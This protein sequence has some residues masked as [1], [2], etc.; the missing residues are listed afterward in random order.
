MPHPTLV[1]AL[2]VCFQRVWSSLTPV[3]L[4]VWCS[5]GGA[6][7]GAGGGAVISLTVDAN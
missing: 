7:G 2:W 4:V 3:V 1:D 5:G 6:D